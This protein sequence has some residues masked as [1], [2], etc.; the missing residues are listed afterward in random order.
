MKVEAIRE[1][2]FSSA[3]L[4]QA[5]I[6][7]LGRGELRANEALAKVP[8][9]ATALRQTPRDT[10]SFPIQQILTGFGVQPAAGP[11]LKMLELEALQLSQ[12]AA[13]EAVMPAD[14]AAASPA[15]LRRVAEALAADPRASRALREALGAAAKG[16]KVSVPAG[17]PR[18]LNAIEQLH[19]DHATD[20]KTREPAHRQLRVYAYDPSIGARLETVDI[21][22]AS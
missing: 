17:P 22:E 2:L 3:K 11:R 10:V 7:H 15:E 16:E 4:N 1:A 18:A 6:K 9:A 12:N 19:L 5:E 20:P 8:A 14:P 21:N 13:I